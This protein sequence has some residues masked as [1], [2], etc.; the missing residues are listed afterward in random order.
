MAGL[1]IQNSARGGNQ[2]LVQYI[3]ANSYPPGARYRLRIW[4][5]TDG[6][7]NGCIEVSAYGQG[8][9]RAI[10]A[11]TNVVAQ[12]WREL[13]L[14]FT[15]PTNGNS[16]VVMLGLANPR[17]AEAA[18]WFD[19]LSVFSD[20]LPAEPAPENIPI[21]NIVRNGG[22]DEGWNPNGL[23]KEWIHQGSLG[24][25]KKMGRE[26]KERS[27]FTMESDAED[28]GNWQIIRQKIAPG[29]YFRN[30]EYVASFW[31]R[32]EG[33]G[34][35]MVSVETEDRQVLA[36]ADFSGNDWQIC[37]F[38]FTTPVETNVTL[39]VR[40]L[41]KSVKVFG[42]KVW[43]D[44][45]VIRPVRVGELAVYGRALGRKNDL[46]RM[47]RGEAG[48]EY[49]VETKLDLEEF[50]LTE[51]CRYGVLSE[52][53]TRKYKERLSAMRTDWER[54][55]AAV[56]SWREREER[57]VNAILLHDD[58]SKDAAPNME[59][60][61]ELAGI[62]SEGLRPIEAGV[63]A[64]REQLKTEKQRL[65]QARKKTEER[66]RAEEIGR[67]EADY[68][69][70]MKQV[71]SSSPAERIIGARE[72]GRLGDS[73]GQDKMIALLKDDDGEV[74][75]HALNGLAW[76]RV[77]EAVEP[78][79]K[80]AEAHNDI[81]TRRRATQA[82]GQIGDERVVGVLMKL[83][84]DPDGAVRQ[85]AIV[86]LGWL[87]ATNATEQLMQIVKNYRR[88][89][90][91]KEL[92]VWQQRIAVNGPQNTVSAAIFALGRIGDQQALPMFMELLS[93]IEGEIRSSAM[94]ALGE[95]GNEQTARELAAFRQKQPSWGQQIE[96]GGVLPEHALERIQNPDAEKKRGLIQPEF[97]KERR[98]FYW[99]DSRFHRGF[100]RYLTWEGNRPPRIEN[101]VR[102][103]QD[104]RGTEFLEWRMPSP[105]SEARRYFDAAEQAGMRCLPAYNHVGAFGKAHFNRLVCYYGAYPAF[106]GLWGEEGGIEITLDDI[107]D[108]YRQRIERRYSTEQRAQ[109]RLQTN[110]C[111]ALKTPNQRHVDI[112][113]RWQER[114][115]FA[116]YA[117]AMDANSAEGA[118]E[119]VEYLHMLKKGS[120]I[121]HYSTI[122]GPSCNQLVNLAGWGNMAHI[123]DFNGTEPTYST[124]AYENGFLAEM[125]RDGL[126]YP[127]GMEVYIWRLPQQLTRR[128]E[129]GIGISLLHSQQMYVWYWGDIFKQLNDKGR[130][131]PEAWEITRRMFAKIDQ[132]EPYLVNPDYP[133]EVAIIHSGRTAGLIYRNDARDRDRSNAHDSWSPYMDNNAGIYQA[134]V[135]E[136]IQADMLWAET[137]TGDSLRPY[138]ILILADA[139]TM[140]EQEENLLRDWV[141]AGGVLIATG[142]TTLYDRYGRARENYGLADVFGAGF[143]TNT[144]R[145]PLETLDTAWRG[146]KAEAQRFRMQFPP[147]SSA[148]EFSGEIEYDAGLGHD[149][150][151]LT[152][153]KALG[154]WT[155]DETTAL[156][157]NQYGKGY[158]FFL[159]ASYP[160][161]MWD[162]G[163]T[164]YHWTLFKRYWTGIREIL[165]GMV[166]TGYK[167][168]GGAPLITAMDCPW[169]V[170]VHAKLQ[171]EQQRLLVQLL[172]Y[173]ERQMPVQGIK[174][175]VLIPDQEAKRVKAFY[176]ADKVALQVAFVDGGALLEVRPFDVHEAV[177]VCYEK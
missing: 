12:V 120:A 51:M 40:L 66:T 57:A 28:S 121:G 9:G 88:D 43:W 125:S 145:W 143:V 92:D 41:L 75:R 71:D 106:S 130:G 52:A 136:H 5:R 26:G 153:A 62:Q 77:P 86:G 172:N 60:L 30:R 42:A 67:F 58:F 104:A 173:D 129:I 169:Y 99:L 22:F 134:L 151:K 168:T 19:D 46:R 17:P 65:A 74:R 124:C 7:N 165:A 163:R 68:M 73:R 133:Q 175:K 55:N 82:L 177:V 174:I 113:A 24:I 116:E 141:R 47:F 84:N 119:M 161:L 25:P 157:L 109:L 115:S 103:A 13:E 128:W 111:A 21:Q 126:R 27:G 76:L 176:A 91:D 29:D 170:E 1:R 90:K 32:T 78:I 122:S 95:A 16:M 44:E 81:W 87:R 167:L 37:A 147:I 15:T 123:F 59:G 171:P 112:D 155:A 110:I 132:M 23:P 56:R 3:P 159:T 166:K 54:I 4:C 131:R 85:N 135:Y 69:A 14:P 118:R 150:I 117:E 164:I 97:L 93:D 146:K 114:E 50:D 142:T 34:E 33:D 6:T 127:V 105:L 70:A 140:T 138:K 72:L 107:R 39:Y 158:C 96:S 64:L 137:M 149:Q 31:G 139:K 38:G 101:F 94:F 80:L 10:L 162:Q 154:Q 98:Y 8:R 48:Q 144:C 89:R 36:S 20:P 152:T 100:G 35:G 102:Y 49:E 160:G 2:Y 148:P 45:F 79:V 108:Y 53:D 63:T 83:M 18:A 11:K 61:D 156:S